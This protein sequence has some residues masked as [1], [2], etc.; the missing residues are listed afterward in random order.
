MLVV[1]YCIICCKASMTGRKQIMGEFDSRLYDGLPY[2]P[3]ILAGK[4]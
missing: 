1:Y 4:S 2:K 3:V